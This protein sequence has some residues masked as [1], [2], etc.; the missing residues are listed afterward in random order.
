MARTSKLPIRPSQSEVDS[1]MITHLPYRSWCPHC[2]RGKSKGKPH[3]K[4]VSEE[5]SIP[6]VALDYMFMHESQNEHEEK[7]MPII[8]AKDLLDNKHGTGMIF[9]R[10]VPQ[11]GVNAYAVKTLRQT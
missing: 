11:K 3:H 7:G 1:H 4:A 6:T 8:V 2:V 10:V 9:A 5:K